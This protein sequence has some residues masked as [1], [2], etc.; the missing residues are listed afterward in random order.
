MFTRM[1]PVAQCA[2]FIFYFLTPQVTHPG[3]EAT[4]ETFFVPDGPERNSALTHDFL[5]RRVTV[6]TAG[7][8]PS[9]ARSLLTS[10]WTLAALGVALAFQGLIS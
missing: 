5:L 4:T 10:A 7:P 1:R 9:S 6:A 2:I 3:Y 8:A